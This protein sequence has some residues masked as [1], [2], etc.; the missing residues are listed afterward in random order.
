M[1]ALN[2]DIDIGKVLQNVILSFSWV[3]FIRKFTLSIFH[4]PWDILLYEHVNSENISKE[5]TEP[6]VWDKKLK[7]AKNSVA[8]FFFFYQHLNK[9]KKL[10][11]LHF[12]PRLHLD[13]I[14]N[15]EQNYQSPIPP[16]PPKLVYFFMGTN[17]F[18][19]N[20]SCF[21]VYVVE[22]LVVK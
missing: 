16:T 12:C 7:Y 3:T 14:Q 22:C 4:D 9:K 13:R 1:V 15:D 2:L 6:L 5:R 8:S 21:D 11:K 17:I 18:L 10:R 19:G 20:I